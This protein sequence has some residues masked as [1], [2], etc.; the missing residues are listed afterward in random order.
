MRAIIKQLGKPE[1]L[2]VYVTDRPGH[3][4]RYAID[5]TKISKELGWLPE[6]VFEDGLSR[7]IQWYKD[8]HVWWENV[9]SGEYRRAE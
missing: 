3:D 6:T 1:S 9:L 7:T 8:N 4:L 5:P 2:I